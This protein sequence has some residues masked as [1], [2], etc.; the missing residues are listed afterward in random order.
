[1]LAIT[2]LEITPATAAG[3]SAFESMPLVTG[4]TPAATTT[5]W[6]IAVEPIAAGRVGRLAVA[7]VVQCKVAVSDAN[8]K[9]VRPTTSTT[10][11]ES[12]DIGEGLLLYTTSGWGLV[13]LGTIDLTKYERYNAARQQI[14]G[15]AANGGLQWLNTTGC[16]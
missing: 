7:G 16:A 4:A 6:G 11:L 5:A 10:E 3:V 9:F 1:V 12:V 14:L 2:G 15:H 13:R 8:H